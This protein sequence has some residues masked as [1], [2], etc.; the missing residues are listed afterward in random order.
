MGLNE[1][2]LAVSKFGA[3]FFA[4]QSTNPISAGKVANFTL[5]GTP[6]AG[7]TNAGFLS[8]ETLPNSSIDGGDQQ[9]LGTWQRRN[10]S[11]ITNDATVSLELTGVQTDAATLDMFNDMRKA[12]VPISIFIVT[13]GPDG[14]RT[15][16]WWPTATFS[17]TG[18]PTHSISGYSTVTYKVTQGSPEEAVK[19]ADIKKG[20]TP[21]TAV[22]ELFDGLRFDDAAFALAA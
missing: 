15:G 20:V 19:L 16:E 18:L 7:W 1:K 9:S 10:T 22:A 3:V 2:G 13:V 14:V 11:S 4:K 12:G 6:P 5:E 17:L 21:T 8:V